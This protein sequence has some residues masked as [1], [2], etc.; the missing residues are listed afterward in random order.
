MRTVF[1]KRLAMNDRQSVRRASAAM[2][3]LS[4]WSASRTYGRRATTACIVRQW[5]GIR[6]LSMTSRTNSG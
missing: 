3:C 6:P 5:P 2:P 1:G 4:E